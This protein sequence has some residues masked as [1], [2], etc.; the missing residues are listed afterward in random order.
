MTMRNAWVAASKV[1]TGIIGLALVGPPHLL[2][3]MHLIQ[4]SYMTVPLPDSTVSPS[5]SLA[6]SRHR[7]LRPPLC[8]LHHSPS[9]L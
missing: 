6:T 9:R 4:G 3:A 2:R 5:T 8:A 7:C 1:A